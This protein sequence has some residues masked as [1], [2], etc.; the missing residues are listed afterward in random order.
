VLANFF[1]SLLSKKG[2]GAADG[3]PAGNYTARPHVY[4]PAG[5]YTVYSAKPH[6]NM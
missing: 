1:N 3:K 2:A 4:K 5:E 6:V